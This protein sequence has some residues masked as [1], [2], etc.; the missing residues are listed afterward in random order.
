MN[1]IDKIDRAILNALQAD[2][3]LS[4]ARLAE[5]VGLSET[6]CARRL[7][8]LE[9]DGYIERYRAMLSRQSLGFGVVA[10]VLV[11][12]AVHDRTLADRFEREVCAI[13]RILSCHNVSGS[14]DYLLQIVARDLDDYG[15]FLRDQLRSLPGVTAVESS[16]SLREVKADGRLPVS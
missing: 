9:Q 2:G 11:R 3:R 13:E 7:R 4:N 1:D 5:L 12:F 16:L 8:R 15:T 10:F 6:P 14:A